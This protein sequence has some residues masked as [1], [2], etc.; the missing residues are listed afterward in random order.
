MR[1]EIL[2]KTSTSAFKDAHKSVDE[3]EDNAGYNDALNSN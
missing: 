2:P 3:Q 1:I